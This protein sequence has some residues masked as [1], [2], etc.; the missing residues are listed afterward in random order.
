MKAEWTPTGGSLVT[1]GDDANQATILIGDFG[2]AAALQEEPLFRGPNRAQFARGNVGGRFT[3]T[4]IKT[5]ASRAALLEYIVQEYG[6]LN[7]TGQLEL[8]EGATSLALNDAILTGVARNAG[9]SLGIRL[10]LDYQFA[11]TSMGT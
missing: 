1:L 4:V 2:G 7:Q 10:A 5:H 3:M 9:L 11:I 6:R 8:T